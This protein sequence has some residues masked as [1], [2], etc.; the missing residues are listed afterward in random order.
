MLQ[1]FSPFSH[2]LKILVSHITTSMGF[3]TPYQYGAC[4]EG[5]TRKR[6]QDPLAQPA[7]QPALPP[8]GTT[9]TTSSKATTL[10][11]DPVQGTLPYMMPTV[12]G[13]SQQA[14]DTLSSLR[15][16]SYK[17]SQRSRTANAAQNGTMPLVM[18]SIPPTASCDLPQSRSSHHGNTRRSPT[19]ASRK[20]FARQ[21]AEANPLEGGSS[22]HESRTK[23]SIA[24]K[25]VESA[26]ASQHPMGI[27]RS[28]PTVLGR[29]SSTRHVP[30]KHETLLTGQ[31]VAV[32][33]SRPR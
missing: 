5:W 1:K 26:S 12:E 30:K 11:A 22:R 33:Q 9:R 17:V 7:A 19:S 14:D 6:I 28:A 31:R 15:S 8:R 27:Q 4:K 20:E 18:S 29:A 16:R 2:L 13:H 3:F 23:H 24:G 21:L 25:Q 32:I 10:Y